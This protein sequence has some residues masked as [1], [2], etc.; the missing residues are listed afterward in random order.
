MKKYI[1]VTKET[2][3]HL[4]KLFKVSSVMLWKALTYESDSL[5]AC[6]IRKAAL[7][8][9][10][11]LMNELPAN[12]TFH[13]TNECM[14]QYFANGAVLEIYYKDGNGVVFLKGKKMRDYS[15]VMLSDIE[16]MQNYAMALR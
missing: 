16:H 6:K 11:I 15:N 9:R 14:R 13:I 2:R 12:E 5:L 8:N 10:G 3:E 1:F 7:E 4:M